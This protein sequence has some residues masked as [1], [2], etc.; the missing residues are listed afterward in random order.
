MVLGSGHDTSDLTGAQGTPTLPP[1]VVSAGGKGGPSVRCA[2][3]QPLPSAL[4][5]AQGLIIYLCVPSRASV[6]VHRHLCPR[7]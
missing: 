3:A 2:A 7:P 1:G 5:G 4:P 6:Q